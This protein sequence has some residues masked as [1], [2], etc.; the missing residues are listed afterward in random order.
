MQRA[1]I[2]CHRGACLMAPENTLASLEAAIALGA[3]AVEF[4]IRTSQD[5]VLYVHH[6]ATVDRTTNGTGRFADLMSFEIDQLDAGTWFDTRFAGERVPRLDT[7]LDACAG[8]IATYAE[9]KDADPAVV[10]DML[11]RRGLLSTAWTFSFDQSIRAQTRAKVPDFRRMVL[12][13]HVGT[14]ERAVALSAHILEFHADDLTPERADA[15]REAGLITQMFY[16]GEDRAVFEHAVRCG[17]QQMNIDH[18]DIYR[19]V[20]A[21]LIATAD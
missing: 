1:A 9:I 12:F 4:D 13:Q 8:R 17:I 20:E 2:V 3:E 7:F 6:D 16:G 14:I 19:E 15:A 11:A 21:E 10:R 5:G 18:V